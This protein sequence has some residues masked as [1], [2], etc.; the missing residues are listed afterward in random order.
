VKESWKAPTKDNEAKSDAY[1]G[2]YVSL[3]NMATSTRIKDWKNYKFRVIRAR[4]NAEAHPSGV[5]VDTVCET[6]GQIQG[7]RVEFAF[8]E[9]V[10][11]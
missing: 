4:L 7:R 9:V 5:T 3:S 10:E 11:Y 2:I 8:S 6:G 1:K